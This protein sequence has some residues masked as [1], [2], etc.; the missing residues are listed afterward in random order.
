MYGYSVNFF[1]NPHEAISFMKANAESIG[2]AFV[3]YRL[4]AMTGIDLIREVNPN[5]EVH[6]ITGDLLASS[7]IKDTRIRSI[8]FKPFN[9]KNIED[10]IRE[11]FPAK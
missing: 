1:A 7:L 10:I 11:K 9:F 2:L 3:D 5:Y 6:I 4:P 8:L